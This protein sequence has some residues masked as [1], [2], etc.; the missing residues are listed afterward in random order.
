MVDII[1]VTVCAFVVGWAAGVGLNHLLGIRRRTAHQLF[2][3]FLW[4]T[5]FI[6]LMFSFL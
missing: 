5:V 6:L 3:V 1:A 4:Q 2:S